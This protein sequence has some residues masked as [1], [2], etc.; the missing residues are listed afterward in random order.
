MNLSVIERQPDGAWGYELVDGQY[1]LV[2][3][4]PTNG[5]RTPTKE[6][7]E[8]AINLLNES[9]GSTVLT[10]YCRNEKCAD[11]GGWIT[12]TA[13]DIKKNI[14]ACDSCKKPMVK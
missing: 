13:E 6:E 10:L 11:K 3:I 8:T 4:D 2:I 14:Y 9:N 1:L 12:R 7:A 5:A